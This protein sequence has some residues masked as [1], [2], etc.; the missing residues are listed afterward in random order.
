M[1]CKKGIIKS[2]TN[3]TGKHL[4]QSLFFN[5]VRG[6]RPATL[7][8]ETLAQMFSFFYGTCPVAASVIS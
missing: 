7:F 2:F 1:F 6:L 8:K 5:K 4:F 3:F